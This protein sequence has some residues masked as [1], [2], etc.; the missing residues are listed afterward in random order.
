MIFLFWFLS[1][2][3]RT[4]AR[5]VWSLLHKGSLTSKVAKNRRLWVNKVTIKGT[6]NWPHMSNQSVLWSLQ[7]IIN[8][9]HLNKRFGHQTL[10]VM[11][12]VSE[13]TKL[14]MINCLCLCLWL[15]DNVT[16]WAVLGSYKYWLTCALCRQAINIVLFE[17]FCAEEKFVFSIFSQV[18]QRR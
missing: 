14:Y 6:L 16:Y 9:W 7:C 12:S 11:I 8:E 4:R 18:S 3:S 2:S 15:S 13:L 10:N 1:S 17:Q 5:S